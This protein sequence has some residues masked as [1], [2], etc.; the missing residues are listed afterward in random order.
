[1]IPRMSASLTPDPLT[2]R[3]AA[4]RRVR[5]AVRAHRTARSAAA[6]ASAAAALSAQLI[7]L[8]E[9]SG[10]RR[11]TCYLATQEEPDP[12]GFLAWAAEHGVEVLLPVSL[13]DRTLAW[14]RAGEGAPVPGRHG[15]L[16]PVGPRLPAS[17][18]GSAD[19]LLIPACAVDRAGTRLG[20]GLGYYDRCLAGLAQRPPVYAVVFAEDRVAGLPRDPHDV[21]VTGV[22]TPAGIG[23]FP[24]ETG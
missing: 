12:S 2:A 20:W 16:E 11:V 23:R 24:A 21:P 15:I 4:K 13:A 9:A 1:M 5:A 7:A 17:A 14:V 3:A 18:A 6:R 10:A 8:V 19:L 22:V